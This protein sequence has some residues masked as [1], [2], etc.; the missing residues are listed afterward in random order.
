MLIVFKDKYIKAIVLWPD[1]ATAEYVSSISFLLNV[2]PSILL[3]EK[4]TEILHLLL[5][6]TPAARCQPLRQ[7]RE[8]KG[9]LGKKKEGVVKTIIVHEKYLVEQANLRT[10][11][12]SELL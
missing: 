9:N 10:A 2:A 5:L 1:L 4:S 8:A 6:I 7:E 3:C 11:W 12:R